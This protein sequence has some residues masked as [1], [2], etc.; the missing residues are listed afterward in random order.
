M[1]LALA[2]RVRRL[3]LQNF[4]LA[5]AYNLLAVPL[6]LAGVVTPLFAAIA[7]S[8]S[9]LLVTLNAL[10]LRGGRAS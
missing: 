9:S 2:R 6:A 7:M 3:I 1:T 8:S 4:S 5:L 10:R